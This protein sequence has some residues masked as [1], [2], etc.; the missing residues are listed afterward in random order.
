MKSCIM[1]FVLGVASVSL[2]LMTNVGCHTVQGA[3]EDIKRVG[4]KG[5]EAIDPAGQK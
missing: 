5:Q 3:G 1:K 4:E 2:V